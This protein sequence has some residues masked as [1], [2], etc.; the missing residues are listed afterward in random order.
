M[1]ETAFT[2]LVG[3]VNLGRQVAPGLHVRPAR[4]AVA[5]P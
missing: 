5:A 2:Y 1:P 3:A 4:R